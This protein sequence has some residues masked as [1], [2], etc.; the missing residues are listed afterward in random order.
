MFGRTG[1]FDEERNNAKVALGFTNEPEVNDTEWSYVTGGVRMTLPDSS[2]LQFSVSGDFETFRSNFLAVP[3]TVT[4]TTARVSLDQRVPS[5]GFGGMAPATAEF[6]QAEVTGDGEKPGGEF[7]FDAVAVGGLKYLDENVL[8]Q[9]LGLGG[10][11]QDAVDQVEDGLLV[12]IDEFL[13][14]GFVPPLHTQHQLGIWIPLARH[15]G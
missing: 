15:L 14:R 13:E 3:N 7:G 1:Y 10:V 8:R 4:R 6:V 5:K 11:A 9:V 12:F 2:D